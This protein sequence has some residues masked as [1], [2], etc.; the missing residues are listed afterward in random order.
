MCSRCKASID[1]GACES[2]EEKVQPYYRR[3]PRGRGCEPCVGR[4]RCRLAAWTERRKHSV[5]SDTRVS[6]RSVLPGLQLSRAPAFGCSADFNGVTPPKTSLSLRLGAASS[7]SASRRHRTAQTR[8]LFSSLTRCEISWD[9]QGQTWQ[10]SRRHHT[11]SSP[12]W[13]PSLPPLS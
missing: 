8:C 10:S 2:K 11:S 9:D 3:A 4:R 6:L 5:A 12:S 7:Q 13:A 1:V